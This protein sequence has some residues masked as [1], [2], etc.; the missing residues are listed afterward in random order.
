MQRTFF[1]IAIVFIVT[2]IV[3]GALAAHKLEKQL[4]DVQLASF[5][6]GTHYQLFNGLGMLVLSLC[7]GMFNKRILASL[8]LIAT[9]TLLFSGSIYLLTTGAESMKGALGPITPIGGSL[10]IVGWAL[11]LFSWKNS[12][13]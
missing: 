13:K 7:Y 4:T 6:T 5:K 12:S 3:L 9:G 8:W 1:R 10:M 11:V 2:G